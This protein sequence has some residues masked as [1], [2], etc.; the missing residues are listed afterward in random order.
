MRRR[1]SLSAFPSGTYSKKGDPDIGPPFRLAKRVGF[2]PTEA[3]TS[4]V[5]KTDSF[6]RSDISPNGT[7]SRIRTGDIDVK[8]RGLSRLSM[9]AYGGPGRSRTYDVSNVA[10]L[11]SVVFA[12]WTY[13][14]IYGAAERTRTSN[15]LLWAPTFQAGRLP[16]SHC[17]VFAHRNYF[18]TISSTVTAQ[19]TGQT[20]K[21]VTDV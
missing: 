5:F 4:S 9:G 19:K 6:N 1:Q 12:N 20:G 7:P 13:R 18:H 11:Q 2:E 15:P 10:D 3:R 21:H 17:C 16:L 14:P 8:G